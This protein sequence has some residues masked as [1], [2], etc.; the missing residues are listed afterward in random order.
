MTVPGRDGGAG[1]EAGAVRR[2]PSGISA[3]KGPTT[4]FLGSAVGGARICAP[5]RRIP[6]VIR[7]AGARV[8]FDF[9]ALSL[10]GMTEIC[11]D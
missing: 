10:H 6:V 5:H 7:R 8:P 3:I 4:D 9:E 1:G 2:A 11:N